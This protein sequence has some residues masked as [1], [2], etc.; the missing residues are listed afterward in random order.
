MGGRKIPL[1]KFEEGSPARSRVL[2]EALSI[3]RREVIDRIGGD[4]VNKAP[5]PHSTG[6]V[7]KGVQGRELERQA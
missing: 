3:F 1:R 2:N 4:R 6:R 7:Y 5:R